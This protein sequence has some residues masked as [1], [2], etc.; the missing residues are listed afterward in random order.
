MSPKVLGTPL[1]KEN[2]RS[3][4]ES[5]AMRSSAGYTWTKLGRRPSRTK[6]SPSSLGQRLRVQRERSRD[7]R[8]EAMF[9]FL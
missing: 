8:S 1:K 9:F 7:E 4:E 6:L 5:S 2:R 3:E